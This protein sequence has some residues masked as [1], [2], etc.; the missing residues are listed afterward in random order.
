MSSDCWNCLYVYNSMVQEWDTRNASGHFILRLSAAS[1]QF[2]FNSRGVP[3]MRLVWVPTVIWSH[4]RIPLSERKHVLYFPSRLW[5]AAYCYFCEF[6]I[7]VYQLNED[8]DISSSLYYVLF[9]L[10]CHLLAVNH[11]TGKRVFVLSE[12]R[13]QNCHLWAVQYTER[14][15]WENSR[16]QHWISWR[17]NS[18]LSWKKAILRDHIESELVE[19]CTYILNITENVVM[20][21]NAWISIYPIPVEFNTS[22]LFKED[23]LENNFRFFFK[24]DASVNENIG[25]YISYSVRRI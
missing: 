14:Y 8:L 11:G 20:M 4:I 3:H 15:S 1:V 16:G 23:Q 5:N 25:R 7:W 10:N 18:I 21:L 12:D 17:I 22:F 24:Q 2:L 13:V 19:Y 9:R 6:H